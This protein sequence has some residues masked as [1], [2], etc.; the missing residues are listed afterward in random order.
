MNMKEGIY[1][2]RKSN[3]L[4]WCLVFVLALI[5]GAVFQDQAQAFLY[6]TP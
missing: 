1:L 5:M 4:K 3:V 2:K 6:P